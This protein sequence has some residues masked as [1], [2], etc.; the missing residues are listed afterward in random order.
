MNT[1]NLKK[2]RE[3]RAQEKAIK[4]RIESVK[5]LAIEE[6]KALCPDGGKFPVEGVGEF[7]LDKDPVLP[8]SKSRCEQAREYRRLSTI[9]DSKRAEVSA[10]SKMMKSLYDTLKGLLAHKVSDYTYTIKCVGLE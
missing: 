2:L 9:R 6:A 5:P 10:V 3:L 4:A 7:I 8:I 1:E